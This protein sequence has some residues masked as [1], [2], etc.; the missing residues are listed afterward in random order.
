MYAKL[1][2]SNSGQAPVKFDQSEAE[3]RILALE[4]GGDGYT[5]T[6]TQTEVEVRVSVPSGT[7]GKDVTVSIKRN[8]LI[9]KHGASFLLNVDRLTAPIDVD[10]S[11]WYMG[12][13]CVIC[14]LEGGGDW[15]GSGTGR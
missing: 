7:R 2:Q 4:R 15:D 6:Q 11:T 8:A 1:G 5:W 12:D 9:V 3:K 14:A 10:E 13:D